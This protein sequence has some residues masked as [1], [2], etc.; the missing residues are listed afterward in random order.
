MGE[1][2]TEGGTSQYRSV[3]LSMSRHSTVGVLQRVSSDL[4]IH[5]GN[6]WELCHHRGTKHGLGKGVVPQ[7]RTAMCRSLSG[8]KG[9]RVTVPKG[10]SWRSFQEVKG[11]RVKGWGRY[12]LR[13]KAQ[14]VG[15]S[16]ACCSV[17]GDMSLIHISEPTRQAESAY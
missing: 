2:V 14:N 12:T 3:V 5:R 16:N 8:H 7:N 11:Y 1:R 17:L 13:P 15:S 6:G 10:G 9:N 4:L